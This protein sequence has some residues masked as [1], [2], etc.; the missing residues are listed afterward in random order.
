MKLVLLLESDEGR[1]RFLARASDGLAEGERI[2]RAT[3]LVGERKLVLTLPMDAAAE[4]VA[5]ETPMVLPGGFTAL[6]S[7]YRVRDA[8]AFEV[9]VGAEG[10]ER[11]TELT[12]ARAGA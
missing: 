1:E 7:Y 11:T 9:S 8:G 10:V 3:E 2:V 4:L 5:R 6:V 12:M